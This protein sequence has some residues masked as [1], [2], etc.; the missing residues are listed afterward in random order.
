M[1]LE[2]LFTVRQAVAVGIGV[3]WIRVIH[4]HFVA[5][6]QPVSV[7][8]GIER[9]GAEPCLFPV[10]QP[11][12]VIVVIVGVPKI[13]MHAGLHC[14]ITV[15]GGI[16]LGIQPVANRTGAEFNRDSSLL[17]DLCLQTDAER[18]DCRKL[19]PFAHIKGGTCGRAQVSHRSD[20]KVGIRGN[21]SEVQGIACHDRERESK[22]PDVGQTG[23]VVGTGGRGNLPRLQHL[24]PRHQSQPVASA[25]IVTQEE[26][27]RR[28]EFLLVKVG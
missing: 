9:I 21:R 5:V 15:G 23:C 12:P 27:T 10:R 20:P 28:S 4:L 17:R 14:Q 1:V 7:G 19:Q 24:H 6:T 11:V 26:I 18:D 13:E 3:E 16:L 8:I 25:G 2:H 22:Q